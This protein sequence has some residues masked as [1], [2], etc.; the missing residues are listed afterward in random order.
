LRGWGIFTPPP[1]ASSQQQLQL[2]PKPG[3]RRVW[4]KRARGGEGGGRGELRAYML[5]NI[6]LGCRLKVVP[7]S[8]LIKLP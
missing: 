2:D 8:S 4:E 3:G 6:G 5:Q 1:V 7:P